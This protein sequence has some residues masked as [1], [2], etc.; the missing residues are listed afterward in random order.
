MRP[1][2]ATP[3]RSEAGFSLVELLVTMAIF[4]VIMGATMTGLSDVI[5][6]NDTV[7]QMANMNNSVRAG[8]DLMVRDLLQV[9]SGLPASHAVTIPSGVGAT[10]VRIPGPPGTNFQTA[11]GDLTL[12]A[13][14]PF[15]RQG[16]TINGVQTDALTV[17]MADNAFIDEALSAVTNTSVTVAPGTNLATGPD[18]VVA[19]QLMLISKGSTNT[20]VQVTAVDTGSRVLTFADGDSLNLN[21]SGAGAGNLTALNAAA[22][23]GDPAATRISRV[24]M[25]S[26]YLEDSTD[27]NHP[28][29]VRRINNGD[30]LTFDN[31]LGTAVSLDAVDLQFAFD[32]V[33]GTNNPGD[34]EM[35]STDLV[36]T[37]A[38]APDPCGRTQVRK[39]NVVVTGRSQNK[40]PPRNTYLHNTLESQVSFRGMAFVD[41]YR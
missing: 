29:L 23:V 34:V 24:R 21:Q 25:I 22:P 12:A 8:M 7:L 1:T 32:I 16:P 41:Q 13:V 30:P 38:C 14:L 28:R 37:G 6:G 5:R 31:D 18:R 9:G 10:Q 20:L 3:P 27:A 39:V 40:V 19:G 4:T 26:Y 2:T 33:N 11:V 35:L 17:L 15:P 36:G